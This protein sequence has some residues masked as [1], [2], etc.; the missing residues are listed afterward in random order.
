MKKIATILAVSAIL[1]GGIADKAE[2]ETG[3]NTIPFCSKETALISTAMVAVFVAGFTF[4]IGD[5][6]QL[7]LVPVIEY[8]GD[9]SNVGFRYTI[10]IGE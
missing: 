7:D 5:E 8:D 1:W 6:N 10:A 2:A 9:E 3:C 4:G